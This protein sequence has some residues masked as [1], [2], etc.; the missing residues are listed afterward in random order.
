[1]YNGYASF[2]WAHNIFCELLALVVLIVV[3][4]LL[5]K[6]NPTMIATL[7]DIGVVY[8]DELI[9]LRYRILGRKSIE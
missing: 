1:M 7:R 6:L 5:F 4:Y 9:A 2:F 3:A 8:Y